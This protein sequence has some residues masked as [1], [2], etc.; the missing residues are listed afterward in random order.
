MF[1]DI[2]PSSTTRRDQLID[3]KILD[4]EADDAVSNKSQIAD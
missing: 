2:R 1:P 4:I 3:P